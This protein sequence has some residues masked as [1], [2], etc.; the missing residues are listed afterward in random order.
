MCNDFVCLT[1]FPFFYLKEVWH[2]IFDLRFVSWI[3]VPQAHKYSIGALSRIFRKIRNDLNSQWDTQR[4]G[5]TYLWKKPEVEN[6][7]SDSL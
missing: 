6:L 4:P 5:D 7:V 1:T 3:S 2:E